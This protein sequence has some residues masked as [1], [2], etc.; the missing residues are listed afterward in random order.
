MKKLLAILLSF[1]TFSLA[2]AQ[3]PPIRRTGFANY[4]AE[5]GAGWHQTGFLG[6]YLKSISKTAD[7]V[8][9]AGQDSS[10][11]PLTFT[12][13]REIFVP[14]PTTGL[15][16][17]TEQMFEDGRV[18][19]WNGE[20]YG[21]RRNV[22]HEA[23]GLN[24]DWS[25]YAATDFDGTVESLSDLPSCSA[26][27][28]DRYQFVRDQIQG[29]RRCYQVG[30]NTY[31]WQPHSPTA[32]SAGR[33]IGR[34]ANEAQADSHATGLNDIAYWH[35]ATSNVPQI[36]TTF[37]LPQTAAYTYYWDSLV[38]VAAWAL[39]GEN[40]LIPVGK[41]VFGTP[42]DGQVVAWDATDSRL[43]WS[44]SSA[45]AP[46]TQAEHIPRWSPSLSQYVP[47]TLGDLLGG[48]AWV[49]DS[50]D[51]F[52]TAGGDPVLSASIVSQAAL[53]GGVQAV[54]D[55][56]VS[57]DGTDGADGADGNNGYSPV[58]EVVADS[59]RRVLR[60]SAWVGGSGNHTG[61]RRPVP[62]IIRPYINPSGCR[63]YPWSDRYRRCRR[64]GSG[65]YRLLHCHS[66]HGS[67][68]PFGPSGCRVS[69]NVGS[70]P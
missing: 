14:S 67:R 9:V 35:D 66:Q 1:V 59:E 15:I 43:E 37:Q 11:D 31:L 6:T 48:L 17:V 33:W 69:A 65:R 45:V 70:L 49:Y 23:S 30:V 12:L 22:E 40:S 54:I 28:V 8:T 50:T 60:L 16:D 52:I 25:D 36:V 64:C 38:D 55:G 46:G 21:A 32:T 5:L 39:S 42:T 2:L 53:D 18:T 13:D 63:Q 24:V 3:G 61:R 62:R 51:Q 26:V 44:A 58:L 47:G 56:L 29:F 68:F 34:F 10:S 41:L 4:P 7:A 57:T 27:R 20:V 19:Y